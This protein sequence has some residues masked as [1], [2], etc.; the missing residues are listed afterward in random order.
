MATARSGA[1]YGVT[2]SLK[3]VDPE[4]E[5][6]EEDPMEEQLVMAGGFND[7]D[8]HLS[9]SEVYSP[10]RDEWREGGSL[11]RRLRGGMSVQLNGTFVAVGGITDE[12]DF[13]DTIYVWDPEELTWSDAADSGVEKLSVGRAYAVAFLVSDNTVQCEG[14]EED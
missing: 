9:T 14:D 12:G 3:P 10:D 7:V 5:E 8:L 2:N 13:S 11:P 1:F 6:E 4:E